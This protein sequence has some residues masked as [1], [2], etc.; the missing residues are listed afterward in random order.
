MRSHHRQ[1]FLSFSLKFVGK[2]ALAGLNRAYMGQSHNI[3]HISHHAF[4]YLPKLHENLTA[5][6]LEGPG[7]GP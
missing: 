4:C 5:I 2:M 7:N 3:R 6:S 1:S